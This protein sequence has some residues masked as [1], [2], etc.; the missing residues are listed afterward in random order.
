MQYGDATGTGDARTGVH[1]VTICT[2]EDSK[3]GRKGVVLKGVLSSTLLK[4]SGGGGG[5]STGGLG[6]D[7]CVPHWLKPTKPVPGDRAKTCQ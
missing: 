7:G 1:C 6:G 2:C 4:S 3:S 5:G